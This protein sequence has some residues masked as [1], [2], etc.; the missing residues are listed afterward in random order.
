MLARKILM[1]VAVTI[2]LTI[3]MTHFVLASQGSCKSTIFPVNQDG[4]IDTPQL[5]KILKQ[6]AAVYQDANSSTVIDSLDFNVNLK[7]LDANNS[8]IQVRRLNN[9]EA[10]GWV[11]RDDLLCARYP[12]KGESGLEQKMYIRTATEVRQDKPATVKA[13]PSP[14]RLACDGQCQELSRF[15][16]YFVFDIDTSSQSFLLSQTYRLQETDDLVGWISQEHG[17][18]WDTAYGLRPREE[19]IF[20]E[21]AVIDGKDVSGQERTVCAYVSLEDALQEKNCQPI[22]GGDRWYRYPHRI[23]IL[24]RIEQEGR[25]F[26]KVVLPLPGAVVQQEGEK[27]KIRPELLGENPGAISLL[28]MK[29]IDVLFLIDGTESMQPYIDAIRGTGE[30][31]GVVQQIIESLRREEA[32]R[33]AEFR[34]GFRMYRDAYA[35][36][37]NLGEGLSLSSDCE[38]TTSR[39]NDLEN[40]ET[41]IAGVTAT[42]DDS[43]DYEENFFGGIRKA[44]R[45]LTACPNNTKILFV[46]GDHGYDIEAQRKYQLQYGQE[47][48]QNWE[49]EPTEMD[50]LVNRLKGNKEEETK[51]I[52][53]FFLQTPENTDPF[54]K[55]P[56]QYKQAYDLFR[57]QALDILGEI[58]P[59]HLQAERDL[60]FMTTNDA[61]LNDRILEGIKNFSNAEAIN[62]LIYDLRGGTALTT[63][64]QRL[65]GSPAYNNIPGLFWELVEQGSSKKLGEQY[66]NRIYDI[67]LTG[68]IPVSE[69]VVEDIWLKS[70]D[71][72]TW[73]DLLRDFEDMSALT[74]TEQR[75]KFTFAIKDA[76]ER[77]I[78]KPPYE[79]TGESLKV[80]LERKGGLPVRDTSV[81]FNYS[82]N[83]ILDDRSVLDCEIDRL[84]GWLFNAKKIMSIIYRGDLRPQYKLE[85]YPG[86]CP[87]GESIPYVDGYISGIPFRESLMRYDH[88]FQK[89][90]IYWVPKEFLP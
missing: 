90:H 75:E 85:K 33:E 19:L 79:A 67:I 53:T 50:A 69:D 49:I 29:H 22:L 58:L 64:I 9:L 66:E 89:A 6:G 48:S 18:V 70:A 71:L 46:I 83:D 68:F 16:G 87:R 41:F 39:K 12:L 78:G 86:E 13:Y 27:I 51:N 74:G 36:K 47:A 32:F 3:L 76:L 55:H 20:P 40:F 45:D 59:S 15:N 1:L 11:E 56:E 82:I 72:D 37:G 7:V 80:Y 14:E 30:R 65:Q 54:L 43:D 63:A 5:I 8:R 77:V 31:P 21:G 2:F 24:E 23:P 60:Y 57:K 10:L 25:A 61:E 42:Q 52:V 28:D 73:T 35:K 17:F 81:L 88:Q 38:S 44:I 84:A 62:E 34:F 26:Y 4:K